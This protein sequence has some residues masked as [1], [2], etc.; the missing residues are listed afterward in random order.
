M[1]GAD[2]RTGAFQPRALQ[3]VEFTKDVLIH[4]G[5]FVNTHHH[6]T[7]QGLSLSAYLFGQY[8]IEKYR[9]TE[10]LQ[11]LQ[12]VGFQFHA[13]RFRNSRLLCRIRSKPSV[14]QK[15]QRSQ[16]TKKPGFA[17]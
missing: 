3:Q 9:Y 17:P 1:K 5:T 6:L 14:L 8:D 16:A 15:I 13:I 12:V 7:S 4:F 2:L 11:R 10:R